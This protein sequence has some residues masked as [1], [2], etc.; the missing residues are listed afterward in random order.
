MIKIDD[1]RLQYLV[2]S[3][4]DSKGNDYFVLTCSAGSFKLSSFSSVMDFVN[5][6][7]LGYVK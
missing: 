6:N 1:T 7:S 3:H 2:E 5:N 4:K